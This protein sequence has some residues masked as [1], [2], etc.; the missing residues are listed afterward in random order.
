[1]TPE[2]AIEWLEKAKGHAEAMKMAKDA[3]EMQIPHKVGFDN[4]HGVYICPEC[5][6]ELDQNNAADWCPH[7]G[8]KIDWSKMR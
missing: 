8:H 2:E 3:L 7:C 4:H 6:N 1:M 5:E